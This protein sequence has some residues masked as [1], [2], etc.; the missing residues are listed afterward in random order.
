[1]LDADRYLDPSENSTESRAE[2]RS[3]AGSSAPEGR[4]LTIRDSSSPPPL[5]STRNAILEGRYRNRTWQR[6]RIRDIHPS[7]S[8]CGLVPIPTTAGGSGRASLACSLQKATLLHLATCKSPWSCP[9]CAPRIAAARAE[10]LAPQLQKMQSEGGTNWL[11]TLTLSHNRDTKLAESLDGIRKAWG[12]VVNGKAWKK[13]KERG[14]I[15]YARGYDVTWSPS[16]GWHPHLHLSLFLSA[17]HKNP[18]ELVRWLVDRWQNALEARGYSCSMQAQDF[19]KT[20]DVAKAAAYAVTPASVYETLS[21]A[22]KRSRGKGAGATP[23]EILS[24]AAGQ[25]IE[26]PFRLSPSQA[27]LLWREYV[28]DTKGR[29]QA[30]T[31]R[32][33]HLVAD[34]EVEEIGEFEEI[35][36]LGK[37]VLKELDRDGKTVWLLD[38]V[39]RARPAGIDAAREAARRFLSACTSRAWWIVNAPDPSPP[40]SAPPDR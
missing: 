22:T 26:L 17:D 12:A 14:K 36:L 8:A 25:K 30:I 35:A 39:E 6:S 15:E 7:L 18:E 13:V 33:L 28:A 16:N 10:S 31:S 38:A 4:A 19:Q 2:P 5:L 1:M 11:V 20:D 21:M 29:R 27:L 9:A 32:G 40:P 34:E 37:E 23:F 3:S 24:T